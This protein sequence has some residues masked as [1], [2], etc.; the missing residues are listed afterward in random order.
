MPDPTTALTDMLPDAKDI[1]ALDNISTQA[2]REEL[3]RSLTLSALHLVRLA[4]IWS[5]LE[6]RG[7]D[8]TD[9]RSGLAVYLPMIASGRLDAEAVVRFAGNRSLLHQLLTLPIEEQRRLAQGGTV[10]VAIQDSGGGYRVA[11]TPAYLLT[12]RL[13]QRVFG[14]GHIRPPAEQAVFLETGSDER[15]TPAPNIRYLADE[16]VLQVGRRKIPWHEVITAIGSAPR[17]QV[18][19]PVSVSVLLTQ[20]E[21]RSLRIRAAEAGQSMSQLVRLMLA[22]AGLI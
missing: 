22:Q 12:A 1:Q 16:R 15:K 7:E 21:H 19:D 6:R 9:L 2:L 13:A 4:A 20:D 5:E 10:P 8:L 3:A 18:D 14:D 17:P 11:Q